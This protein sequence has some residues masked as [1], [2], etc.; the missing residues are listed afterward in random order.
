MK[1]S[2]RLQSASLGDPGFWLTESGE[3][4]AACSAFKGRFCE[5]LSNCRFCP[6]TGISIGAVVFTEGWPG[7]AF[8]GTVPAFAG[9]LAR[10]AFIAPTILAMTLGVMC[11]A[12]IP[13]KGLAD[14][15][16]A[17]GIIPLNMNEGLVMAL[18]MAAVGAATLCAGA[19]HSFDPEAIAAMARGMVF[20][21]VE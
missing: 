16:V 1:S 21:G 3:E 13:K 14:V 8:F 11:I 9:V 15:V 20:K 4:R 6:S 5:V 18:N 17:C 19:E 7:E 12:G 10:P 2:N